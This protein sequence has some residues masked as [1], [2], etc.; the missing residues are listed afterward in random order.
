MLRQVLPSLTI[1]YGAND[2]GR[3]TVALAQIDDAQT[4]LEQLTHL[5]DLGVR[6]YC[7]EVGGS[8]FG[9]D[10]PPFVKRVVNVV[11][12]RAQKEV[13]WVAAR[14][15][16]ALVQHPLSFRYSAVS[17]F[18]R[19]AVRFRSSFTPGNGKLTVAFVVSA[20]LPKPAI[21]VARF[22]YLRPEALEGVARNHRRAQVI[23]TVST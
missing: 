10:K 8:A 4:L 9:A 17:N 13:R 15:V 6:Q 12:N 14:R 21:G 19:K 22:V 7:P 23:P 16:V 2:T 11:F 20:C 1:N 5:Y 18:P 3:D